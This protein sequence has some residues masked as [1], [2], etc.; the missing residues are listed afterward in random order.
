MNW[1]GG[2][3]EIRAQCGFHDEFLNYFERV[4]FGDGC[5]CARALERRESIIIADVTRD[6]VF[7][8]CLAIMQNAGVRAVQS[9]PLV[10]RYGAFVGVLSTH[11]A[12]VHRPTDVQIRAASA[13]ARSAADAIVRLYGEAHCQAR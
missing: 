6:P 8:P 11:F 2:F 12:D 13:A 3:L 4:K 9:T 5:A 10:S 1:H 7:R